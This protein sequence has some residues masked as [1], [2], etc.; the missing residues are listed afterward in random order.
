MS[1]VG[2][3]RGRDRGEARYLIADAYSLPA[4]QPQVFVDRLPRLVGELE[5][6]GSS[7]LFFRRMVA[8]SLE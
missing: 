6:D 8:R 4:R 2:R 1:I 7:G 3:R 5:P